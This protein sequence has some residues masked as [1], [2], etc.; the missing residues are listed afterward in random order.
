MKYDY[1]PIPLDYPAAPDSGEMLAR[2]QDYVDRISRRRSVRHFSEK[3]VPRE[4]IEA[5]LQA[6]GSAP[7]GANHQPWHFACVSDPDIKRKIRIAAEEEERAFYGGRAGDQWLDDLHGLG[8]DAQKPF[9]ETAPWLIAIFAERY[10]FDD[11][12]E[13]Q[14]NYYVAE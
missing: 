6:A 2:A 12:G 8:T 9:I 11:S 13:K 5:C 4:V 7:S 1:D 3:S 10:G 14:K